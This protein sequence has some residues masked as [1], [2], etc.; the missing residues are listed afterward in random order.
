MLHTPAD[1]R[2][3]VG[4]E[5]LHHQV[6]RAIACWPW[7]HRFARAIQCRDERRDRV[8]VPAAAEGCDR[9]VARRTGCD[10]RGQVP[11]SSQVWPEEGGDVFSFWLNSMIGVRPLGRVAQLVRAPAS[12][13]GGRRFESC[14][15]HHFESCQ[16][17]HAFVWRRCLMVGLPADGRPVRSGKEKST[18]WRPNGLQFPLRHHA[19]ACPEHRAVHSPFDRRLPMIG[20][21]PYLRARTQRQVGATQPRTRPGAPR[22]TEAGCA[23]V[24][25]SYRRLPRA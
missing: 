20:S 21:S 5:V 23:R 25:L 12:H 14:R 15:A 17:S 24:L 8:D 19:H 2:G 16:A 6:S 13:A 1:A 7:C 10:T 11:A 9:P 18:R 3:G 4:F 22:P